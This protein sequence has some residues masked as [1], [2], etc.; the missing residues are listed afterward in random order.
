M[1]VVAIAGDDL[2]AILQRHLHADDDSFLADVKVTEAADEAHAVK[3][4]GLLFK[5][6]DQEHLTVSL[7]LRITIEICDRAAIGFLGRP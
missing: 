7:E 5:A 4:A 2:I 6:A 1:A 3:L